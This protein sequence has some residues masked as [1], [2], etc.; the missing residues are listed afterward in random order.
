LGIFIYSRDW[1]NPLP[2]WVEHV[3]ARIPTLIGWKDG[4]GDVGRYQEIMNR[5]GDR[6]YWIGGPGD[7]WV[8]AYYGIGIRTYTSSI[9][10]VAPK[11]SLQLHEAAST[12]NSAVLTQ[13]IEEYVT[14]LFTLRAGRKGYEVSVMKEMM[15]QIGLAA[16]PVRPPSPTPTGGGHEGEADARKVETRFVVSQARRH[17]PSYGSSFVSRHHPS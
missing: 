12:G 5:V 13:L 17:E 16:G 10:T 14:T 7:A 15:N 9:A 8:P 2:A 3:A 1:V 4:Q 6:L 11:L